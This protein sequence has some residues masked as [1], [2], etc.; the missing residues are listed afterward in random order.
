MGEE[1]ECDSCGLSESNMFKSEPYIS[2]P[3]PLLAIV[4]KEERNTDTLGSMQQ[5]KHTSTITDQKLSLT[6]NGRL[7]TAEERVM[8]LEKP[9]RSKHKDD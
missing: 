6:A 2:L 3:S 7:D 9:R 5:R 8:E 4:A 1:S